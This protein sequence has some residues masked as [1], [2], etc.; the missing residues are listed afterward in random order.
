[1]SH[2]LLKKDGLE[3]IGE[4]AQL[5]TDVLDITKHLS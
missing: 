5:M 3:K 2:L 1:M 4:A